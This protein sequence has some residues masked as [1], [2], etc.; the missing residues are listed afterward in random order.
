MSAEMKTL[1]D[2]PKEIADE[3]KAQAQPATKEG[4][5]NQLVGFAIGVPLSMFYD[6]LYDLM[7][8]KVITNEIAKDVIKVVMPLGIG[9]AVHVAKVPF[10]NYIA[11]TAYAV[12]IISLAK[13]VY[14]RVKGLIGTKQ[15]GDVPKRPEGY[16]GDAPIEIWGVQG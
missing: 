10:G 8:S 13:I 12:A 6:W 3:V 9:V 11:G 15:V 14:S 1:T 2:L 5:V 4:I 7:A 16:V